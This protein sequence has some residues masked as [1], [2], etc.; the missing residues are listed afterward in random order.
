VDNDRAEYCRGTGQ[1]PEFIRFRLFKEGHMSHRASTD[2]L[3]VLAHRGSTSLNRY[4]GIA[5]SNKVHDRSK[6]V[7]SRNSIVESMFFQ[8]N[9]WCL[10]NP[11]L[12]AGGILDCEDSGIIDMAPRAST[13][14]PAHC[15]KSKDGK[16]RS[17]LDCTIRRFGFNSDPTVWQPQVRQVVQVSQD[18]IPSATHPFGNSKVC[19]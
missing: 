14:S 6:C 18:V 12:E 10:S 15:G 3:G 11:R 19:A 8:S 2:R 16:Q 7:V 17:L 1:M 5:P 13:P 9:A 4:N